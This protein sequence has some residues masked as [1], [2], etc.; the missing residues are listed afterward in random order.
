A[1]VMD[2]SLAQQF[3]A[4]FV[5]L[6]GA[7][8]DIHSDGDWNSYAGATFI[9]QGTVEKTGGSGKWVLNSVTLVNTGPV[10]S[11]S[12]TLDLEGSG[13]ER[14]SFTAAAGCTLTFGHS[15]WG[16]NAGASVSGAGS[17]SF[18]F[19]YWYT[20]FNAGSSYNVSGATVVDAAVAFLPGSAASLGNLTLDS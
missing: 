12:G 2:D 4:T 18:P 1:A 20:S 6:P 8:L 5:N 11:D 17:V 15:Y 3:G 13:V 7:T 14:G 9:N 19:D 16:F 10:A